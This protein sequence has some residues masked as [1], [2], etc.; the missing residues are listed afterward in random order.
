MKSSLKKWIVAILMGDL[1]ILIITG[2]IKYKMP[3]QEYPVS[4]G[5]VLMVVNILL[6]LIMV[7]HSWILRHLVL[8]A[9]IIIGTVTEYAT[10]GGSAA[11]LTAL[12]GV[13]MQGLVI[14]AEIVQ[15][16]KILNYFESIIIEKPV[17]KPFL[18]LRS[19]SMEMARLWNRLSE[20]MKKYDQLI[21]SRN[22]LLQGYVRFAP[23]N[24]EKLLD[25]KSIWDIADGDQVQVKGTL[26]MISMTGRCGI[27]ALDRN[28]KT[29]CKYGKEQEG[30]VF[31]D[32][33]T[34]TS[35]KV[36]FMQDINKAVRFGIDF[37]HEL[38]ENNVFKEQK[39]IFILHNDTIQYGISG[40][41]EQIF[42]YIFSEEKDA[43]QTYL[44]RLRELSVRMV[45]TEAVAAVM[46]QSLNKRYLGYV[47]P[48]SLNRSIK[49][50][51]VLDVYG[52]SKRRIKMKADGLF[53][54]GLALYYQ[55]DFYLARNKFTDVIKECPDDL[56]AKWYIFSCEK[57]INDNRYNQFKYGLLAE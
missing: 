3:E 33:T 9:V 37:M 50:Y 34:L 39:V 28:I 51:E 48:E 38:N 18:W 43:L 17:K 1:L 29:I 2:Y 13:V 41:D 22:R 26:G 16:S 6:Y 57:K 32:D 21:Y 20:V 11:V 7:N 47:E 5:I 52:E 44:I 54:E 40:T 4:V 31:A 55:N 25:K 30:M 8:T 56:V 12:T 46:D 27:S 45:V 14:I 49:L 53:Q 24:I 10:D 36:L 19:R 15:L 23:G 35:L 42:S